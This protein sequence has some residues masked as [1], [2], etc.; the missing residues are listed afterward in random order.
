MRR[1][2]VDWRLTDQD[3]RTFAQMPA[4]LAA[5]FGR[6]DIGR[7]FTSPWLDEDALY[8]YR[9]DFSRI[10][11]PG[12]HHSGTTRMASDANLGVVNSD[13]R[14]FEVENAFIAGSSVFPTI[15]SANPTLTIV[16]LA[17]RLAD[18]LKIALD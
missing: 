12:R 15:G 17:L 7:V 18:H 6:L 16:A 5:E 14:I 8:I 13:C 10:L 11:E 2:L 4:V 3:R 9:D 1:A